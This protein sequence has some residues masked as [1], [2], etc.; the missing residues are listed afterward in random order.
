MIQKA[1]PGLR[2]STPPVQQAPLDSY[3]APTQKQDFR[4]LS[5]SY[6]APAASPLATQ[7]AQTYGAPAEEPA[8][9]YSTPVEVQQSVEPIRALSGRERFGPCA[10][11]LERT[12]YGK[13]VKPKISKD[14]FL[15]R[16]PTLNVPYKRAYYDHEPKVHYNLVFLQAPS[17][18]DAQHK[19]IVVPPPKQQ[20][21]VYLL[22]KQPSGYEQ[23]VIEV[24]LEPTKPEVFFVDYKDGDNPIL[25]G[26]IDLNTA[27]TQ[28]AGSQT[29]SRQPLQLAQE[30]A[31]LRDDSFE[32][33]PVEEPI[34]SSSYG[35]PQGAP[36][37]G[38]RS[39]SRSYGVP[40]Q[41]AQKNIFRRSTDSSFEKEDSLV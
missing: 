7:P 26:G 14:L 31:P 11:G 28:S 6:G 34:L 33:A 37:T 35:V 32:Q 39:L 25:P 8:P 12:L 18:K 27:L 40:S 9:L 16:A 1:L 13:C 2:Y 23:D 3:S 38:I 24:P 10:E 5:D 22:S 29:L 41:F 36:I 30:P 4:E 19:P 17:Y 15:Y 21:L 20:T